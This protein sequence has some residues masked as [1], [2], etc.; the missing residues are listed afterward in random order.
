M[1]LN[2]VY[3]SFWK[4]ETCETAKIDWNMPEL[5]TQSFNLFH[6]LDGTVVK[7]ISIVFRKHGILVLLDFYSFLKAWYLV[8]LHFVTFQL[9]IGRKHISKY[10][11]VWTRNRQ[12]SLSKATDLQD[13]YLEVNAE[14][15]I[16][17]LDSWIH[18]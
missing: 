7:T 5:E 14:S 15:Y 9:E 17:F 11:N 2:K 16:K 13:I 3:E 4:F 10:E 8:L 18:L 6:N 1:G 12:R